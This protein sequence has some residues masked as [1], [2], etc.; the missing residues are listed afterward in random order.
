MRT[1]QPNRRQFMG[2]MASTLAAGLSL[3]LLNAHPP[4]TTQG[5]MPYRPLGR[6][7]ENVSLLGMGGWHLGRMTTDAECT[8]FVHAAIASGVHFMDNCWD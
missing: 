5:D 4:Y 1:H 6:T 2:D 8:G 7:G 3:P